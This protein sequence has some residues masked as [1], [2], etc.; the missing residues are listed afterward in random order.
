MCLPQSQIHRR[1]RLSIR[2]SSGMAKPGRDYF[3]THHR[4]NNQP[5]PVKGASSPLDQRTL[6]LLAMAIIAKTKDLNK[7]V[8]KT[9]TGKLT[10]RAF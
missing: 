5:V 7:I 10:G 1:R 6:R 4:T 2:L 3:C 8:G 9:F